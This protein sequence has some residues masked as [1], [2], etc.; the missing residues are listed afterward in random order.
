MLVERRRRSASIKP[1]LVSILCLLV[2]VLDAVDPIV[3]CESITGQAVCILLISL[4]T[5]RRRPEPGP[6]HL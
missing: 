5:A 6:E 3:D 4:R 2:Y 1:A